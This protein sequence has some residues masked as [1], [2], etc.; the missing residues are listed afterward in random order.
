MN[1]IPVYSGGDPPAQD[2]RVWCR[3]DD[4]HKV[5]TY[6]K[7]V[8]TELASAQAPSAH[9]ASHKGGG[10]DA[11]DV[12]GAVN[13]LM[14]SADKT[15]LD[16][17][18]AS[19]DKTDAANVAAAGAVM[20][21]GDA[22]IKGWIHFDGT[23]VIAIQDS[24]NV[25]S[26]TDNGVGNYTVTWDKDFANTNYAV[27]PGSNAVTTPLVAV[28]VGSCQIFTYSAAHVGLDVSLVF[29]VAIGDQ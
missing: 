14:S 18:E 19:A 21:S 28:A 22:A 20:E 7:G 3:S 2:G 6:V 13:G 26:I 23:G 27:V 11:I 12:A 16:G 5:Y 15:K 17:I 1:Q 10:S 9:A 25:T 24:F 8:K 29:C 4:S